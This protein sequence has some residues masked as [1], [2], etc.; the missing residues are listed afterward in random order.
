MSCDADRIRP[1]HGEGRR[2]RNARA[3]RGRS[4]PSRP[5]W[6]GVALVA[7]ILALAAGPAGAVDV[8]P[9]IGAEVG[10]PYRL[11]CPPGHLLTG[12]SLGSQWSD[13]RFV[14]LVL[15]S[16]TCRRVGPDGR[17]APRS[18][19]PVFPGNAGAFFIS[20]L[21]HREFTGMD[22]PAD[23]AIR[24]IRVSLAT[25]TPVIHQLGLG[26][27]NPAN[28]E[29]HIVS[30]RRVNT[31]NN[32]PT[33]SLR[34]LECPAGEW[35][36]GIFGRHNTNGGVLSIGLICRPL[37]VAAAPAGQQPVAAP[38]QGEQHTL[39]CGVEVYR[40]PGSN[41]LG[42]LQQGDVVTLPQ[43]CRAD[44]WCE[45]RGQ[46]VP[47]GGGWVYSGPDWNA[48]ALNNGQ[49]PCPPPTQ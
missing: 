39:A 29:V 46:A 24:T 16:T 42:V 33:G 11:E 45:V 30:D 7:C 19:T 14:S 3:P 25:T 5:L 35:G 8:G 22:C 34:G 38:P 13:S 36:A 26:C 44:N 48:L 18:E 4:G 49:P 27:Q 9:P 10:S 37:P 21:L 15:L 40:Q 20:D 28:T 31:I 17:V 41:R 12:L 6:P 2:A 43:A 23:Q 1:H 47:G 32:D